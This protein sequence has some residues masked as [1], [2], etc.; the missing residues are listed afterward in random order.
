MGSI[1]PPAYQLNAAQARRLVGILGLRP[2]ERVLHLGPPD[3]AAAR[4]ASYLV[5]PVGEVIEADP[6]PADPGRQAMGRL[7][8]P[9]DEFDAVFTSQV[10][11][12]VPT[13]LLAEFGR[14]TRPTGRVAFA[15]APPAGGDP[16][17][18]AALVERSG[19]RGTGIRFEPG[20]DPDAGP[21]CLVTAFPPRPAS[22]NGAAIPGEPV[23][24][25]TTEAAR[26]P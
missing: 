6:G 5:G 13:A 26:L 16:E 1:D 14:V 3:A 15:L 2:G 12:G 21:A 17:W 25:T 18:L 9:D 22:D 8:F 11:G 7:P 23:A 10:A 19:L 4:L 20:T 24:G